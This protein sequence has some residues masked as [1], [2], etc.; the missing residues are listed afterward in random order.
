MS[1]I[2]DIIILGIVALCIFLGYKRG[3]AKC[4]IKVASFFIAIVVAFSLYKPVSNFV[5]ENTTFD[6]DIKS[7]IAKVISGE[8]K[9][10]EQIKEESNLPQSMID[11]INQEIGDTVEKTKD[12]MVDGAAGKIAEVSI[13]IGTGILLFILTRVLLI[14]VSMLFK[15][16]TDLPV[17]K[18]VDKAGGIIYGILKAGLIIFIV[19]AIISLI[20]PMIKDTGLIDA[21]NNSLIGKILY[22]NNILFNIIK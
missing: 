22:N 8:V 10:D 9:D 11:L 6:E 18:Q 14:F 3:L 16:I 19:F 7:S 12:Q 5:I 2:I 1:T 15:S 17:I 20:S 13:E 21:I 4:V